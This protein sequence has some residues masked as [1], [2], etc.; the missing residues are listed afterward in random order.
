MAT[1]KFE[2]SIHKPSV[3]M[4]IKEEKTKQ[5]VKS[6]IFRGRLALNIGTYHTLNK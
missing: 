2:K 4:P 5:I 3:N 6:V 1:V